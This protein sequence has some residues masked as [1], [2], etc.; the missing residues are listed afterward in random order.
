MRGMSDEGRE[1]SS[2]LRQRH[3]T[4]LSAAY[5]S[6]LSTWLHEVVVQADDRK[7]SNRIHLVVQ[8]GRKKTPNLLL[9]V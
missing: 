9:S 3:K 1:T 2:N 4:P 6:S 7:L 8:G 5:F